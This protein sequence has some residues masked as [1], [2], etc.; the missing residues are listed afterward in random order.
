[1]TTSKICE[2][3]TYFIN[4]ATMTITVCIIE[5]DV[6]FARLL[7]TALT[8]NSSLEVSVIAPD[9]ATATRHIRQIEDTVYLVDLNLPDGSGIDFIQAIG[10]TYPESKILA[11]SSLGD[12]EHI[13]KSIQA[14]AN[15]YIL[16]SELSED[17][18]DSILT[19]AN[20][21]AFLSPRAS[22][23]LVRHFQRETEQASQKSP[24][25]FTRWQPSER[26]INAFEQ[27]LITRSELDALTSIDASGEKNNKGN[28]KSNRANLT[29]KE[30]EVL[31]N[32]RAGHPAKRISTLLD[33]S[34]FTV[35]QHLRSIYRK[36]NVSNKMSAV[37]RAQENNII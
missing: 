14:G 11:L 36:L 8:Q 9:I 18:I 15:G 26:K 27:P 12:E 16:K 5:D 7:R 34:V 29:A 21:G 28:E 31:K 25:F 35:N 17:I 20:D 32:V 22:N 2:I 13:L 19:L 6:G 30:I 3:M 10:T 4:L 37:Q 23:V 1:M 24:T 33:I